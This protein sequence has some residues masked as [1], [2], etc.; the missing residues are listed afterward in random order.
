MSGFTEP[1][2]SGFVPGQDASAQPAT[3]REWAGRRLERSRK[4]G[5]TIVAYVVI[6]LFLIGIWAAVGMGYFWPGWVLAGWGVALVLESWSL[7]YTRAITDADIE[8]EMRKGS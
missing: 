2:Q 3:D 1:G 4:L 7:S 8:R 6:N 5:D